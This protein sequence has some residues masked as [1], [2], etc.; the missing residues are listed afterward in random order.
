MPQAYAE[1][2][3]LRDWLVL[4]QTTQAAFAGRIGYSPTSMTGLIRGR[5]WVSARIARAI[6]RETNGAVTVRDLL[7]T[8]QD[9]EPEPA[10]DRAA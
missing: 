1:R 6:E 5:K 8:M 2:M 4:T 9:E 7:D 10:E 3:R